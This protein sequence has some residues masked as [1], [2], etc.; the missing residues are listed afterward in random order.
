M[1]HLFPILTGV[2]QAVVKVLEA[3]FRV[4]L[5]MEP[6]QG[7]SQFTQ[8]YASVMSARLIDWLIG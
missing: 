2:A 1:P 4:T 3:P 5:T 7:V 8:L 6:K